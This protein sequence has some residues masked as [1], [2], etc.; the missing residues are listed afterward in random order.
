[1][2]VNSELES[3]SDDL[4]CDGQRRKDDD[5]LVR[6]NGDILRPCQELE[7]LAHAAVFKHGATS[8]SYRP[9]DHRLLKWLERI[10]HEQRLES[11]FRAFMGFDP[12]KILVGTHYDCP[13]LIVS[14]C[15]CILPPLLRFK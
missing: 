8:L 12:E 6:V 5:R 7:R 11:V 14:L 3:L 9:F 4:L 2:Y 1:M 15:C 13:E 10:R